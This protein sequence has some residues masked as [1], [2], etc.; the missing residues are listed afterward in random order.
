MEMN[1][2][3][4]DSFPFFLIKKKKKKKQRER[5]LTEQIF[6]ADPSY[7][8][9]KL[10]QILPFSTSYA[11]MLNPYTY[12]DQ[13]NYYMSRKSSRDLKLLSEQIVVV[14]IFPVKKRMKKLRY[15]FTKKKIAL[16]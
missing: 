2:S 8:I 3:P 6:L 13:G 1:N 11:S 10:N 14:I 7:Y 4:T 5:D 9:L 12:K 16:L 15:N